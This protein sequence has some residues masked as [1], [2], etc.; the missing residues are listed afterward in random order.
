[1]GTNGA[2]QKL[3]DKPTHLWAPVEQ[4]RNCRINPPTYGHRWNRAETPEINPLTYGHRW[5]RAETAE[6]NPLTYGHL[7]FDK[8]GRPEYTMV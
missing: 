3:Q 8:G 2:G 7:I 5:S 4:G 1:M 6:I